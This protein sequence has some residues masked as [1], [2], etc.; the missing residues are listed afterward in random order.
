MVLK[1]REQNNILENISEKSPQFLLTW[2]EYG[3]MIHTA[4]KSYISDRI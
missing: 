1:S 2:S 4:D 3:D